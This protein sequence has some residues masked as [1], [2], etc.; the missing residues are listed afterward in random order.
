MGF[1]VGMDWTRRMGSW[2]INVRRLV[3]RR[4]A[5]VQK[6]V[7]GGKVEINISLYHWTD[8]WLQ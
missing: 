6:G 4:N 7:G 5:F 2:S 3:G 1:E 8:R